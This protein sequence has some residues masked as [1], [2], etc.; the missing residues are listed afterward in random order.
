MI[1][2]DS[3]LLHIQIYQSISSRSLPYFDGYHENFSPAAHQAKH[4]TTNERE[5]LT[6]KGQ[7]RRSD[8][9]TNLAEKILRPM[10]R[11]Y[12]ILRYFTITH[13]KSQIFHDKC[14]YSEDTLQSRTEKP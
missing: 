14:R 3:I 4:P 8:E 2:Y 5:N 7:T 1:T 11:Y 13:D 9:A 6:N 10:S 12:D